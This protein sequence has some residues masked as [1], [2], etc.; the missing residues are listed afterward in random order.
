MVTARMSLEEFVGLI[1]SKQVQELANL[2]LD[3]LPDNIPSELIRNSAQPLRGLLEKMA[4]DIGA[5]EL[6]E[7]Q[8]FERTFGSTAARAVD[9]A[10][11]NESEIA[12]Q[13]LLRKI[14]DLAP[15]WK[16]GARRK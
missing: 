4:F 7:Q 13:M 14:A 3:S 16:A 11:D 12:H 8:Q 6:Q 1:R 9:L 10:H 15:S 2:P 5:R